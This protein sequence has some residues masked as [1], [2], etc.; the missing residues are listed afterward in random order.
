MG[1]KS[2]IK[3]CWNSGIILLIKKKIEKKKNVICRYNIL[4]K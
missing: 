1:E 4:K 3:N 2:N